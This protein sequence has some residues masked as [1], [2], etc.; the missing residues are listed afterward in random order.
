MEMNEK[1][2]YSEKE[3]MGQQVKHNTGD[4]RSNLIYWCNQRTTK[5]N[6]IDAKRAKRGK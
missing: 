4:H 3:P 1:N 5:K 2:V 6:N